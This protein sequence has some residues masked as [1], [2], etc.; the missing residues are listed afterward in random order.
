VWLL[1]QLSSCC[2]QTQD[3]W[4]DSGRFCG[5]CLPKITATVRNWWNQWCSSYGSLWVLFVIKKVMMVWH[6]V[7]DSHKVMA[8]L[9]ILLPCN[10]L[11]WRFLCVLRSC[12]LSQWCPVWYLQQ[13][14][15]VFPSSRSGC[16]SHDGAVISAA[17][18]GQ[19]VA[20]WHKLYCC[21][22]LVVHCVMWIYLWLLVSLMS[23]FCGLL[24]GY[25]F[26]LASVGVDLTT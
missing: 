24:F 6:F 1:P 13:L 5:N 3:C 25:C 12:N 15:L 18:R 16:W 2:W 23:P 21:L 26:F 8:V 22:M 14:D 11:L 19:A 4:Q 17:S 10:F 20:Y 7:S 9:I